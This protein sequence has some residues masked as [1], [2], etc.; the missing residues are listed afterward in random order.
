MASPRGHLLAI[1]F[2]LPVETPLTA[3]VF[4]VPKDLAGHQMVGEREIVNGIEEKLNPSDVQ[5]WGGAV[6]TLCQ[7]RT[8][9][10]QD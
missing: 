6:L 2:F 10:G 3:H 7:L 9:F 8:A 4:V 5:G 1:L